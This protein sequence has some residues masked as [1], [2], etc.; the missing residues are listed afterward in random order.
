MKNLL[1]VL[2]GKRN[3][4]TVRCITVIGDSRD[5]GRNMLST[6]KRQPIELS[7][8][9]RLSHIKGLNRREREDVFENARQSINTEKV[10]LQS[11]RSCLQWGAFSD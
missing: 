10:F 6:F 5:V 2:F 1:N 3:K 7:L 4:K 8:K 9:E 11:R